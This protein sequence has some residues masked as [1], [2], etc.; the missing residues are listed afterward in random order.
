MPRVALWGVHFTVFDCKPD[1]GLGNQNYSFFSRFYR[2]RESNCAV[3]T[4]ASYSILELPAG[5]PSAAPLSATAHEKTPGYS[6]GNFL[7]LT[8]VP[9]FSIW[10]VRKLVNSPKQVPPGPFSCSLSNSCFCSDPSSVVTPSPVMSVAAAT[11]P[12]PLCTCDNPWLQQTLKGLSAGPENI[13]CHDNLFKSCSFLDQSS[14]FMI[15]DLIWLYDLIMLL[16]VDHHPV[17]LLTNS[18]KRSHSN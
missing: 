10:K 16:S 18:D 14:M 12:R 6:I 17:W 8:H 4:S 3:P 11:G 2:V 5:K 1:F 13:K 15:I 9:I 7:D